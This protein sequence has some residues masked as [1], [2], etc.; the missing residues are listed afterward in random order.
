ME[1]ITEPKYTL[2][3]KNTSKPLKVPKESLKELKGIIKGKLLANMKKEVVDCPVKNKTVA[4]IECFSCK[5]F[6]RRVK[7]KV[8]CQGLP[9]N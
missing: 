5:N 9:L 6:L 2:E 1:K 7:G 4:F 8:D 3:I